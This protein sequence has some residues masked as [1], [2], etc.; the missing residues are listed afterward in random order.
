M[1]VKFGQD[2]EGPLRT[3]DRSGL[4]WGMLTDLRHHFL[5]L[6]R[7]NTADRLN[8]RILNTL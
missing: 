5:D 6:T 2:K 4:D 1:F 7:F 3:L 8:I